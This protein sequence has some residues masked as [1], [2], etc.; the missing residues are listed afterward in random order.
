[1]TAEVQDCPPCT[2]IPSIDM[3]RRVVTQKNILRTA[4]RLQT[5]LLFV[6]EHLSLLTTFY[7]FFTSTA[8]ERGV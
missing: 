5:A 3:S 6:G 4:L 7:S 8:H 2:F 1:M